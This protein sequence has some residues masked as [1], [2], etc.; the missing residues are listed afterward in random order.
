MDAMNAMNGCDGCGGGESRSGTGRQSPYVGLRGSRK[1]S[2]TGSCREPFPQA[3]ISAKRLHASALRFF[4]ACGT[5][6]A[7]NR[8]SRVAAGGGW[9]E[10]R[11]GTGRQPPYVGNPWVQQGS[12]EEGTRTG[13]RPRL[14]TDRLSYVFFPA[15]SGRKQDGPGRPH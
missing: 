7:A 4:T 1:R 2:R 13:S 10:S 8:A 6:L 9:E 5:G 15:D 3:L 11:N 12:G 14:R